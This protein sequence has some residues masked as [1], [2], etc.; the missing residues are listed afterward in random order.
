MNLRPE[1]TPTLVAADALIDDVLLRALEPSIAALER[2][3]D[4]D[5]RSHHDVGEPDG[6][7]GRSPR[8]LEHSCP[9]SGNSR[10]LAPL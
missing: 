1:A 2:L 7:D 6:F 9:A 3:F 5:E 8:R 4:A 10:V